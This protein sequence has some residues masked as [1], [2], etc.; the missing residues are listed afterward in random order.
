M[1]RMTKVYP[2]TFLGCRD[3]HKVRRLGGGAHLVLKNWISPTHLETSRP[4]T[5]F[6]GYLPQPSD[7]LRFYLRD[8]ISAAVDINL[9][10]EA[11]KCNEHPK[12]T[13]V[14]S[15]GALR[16]EPLV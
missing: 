12:I 11:V 4:T 14:F 10:Y 6:D 16:P 13:T 15:F 2:R 5:P 7:G 9:G 1:I 8:L 3:L